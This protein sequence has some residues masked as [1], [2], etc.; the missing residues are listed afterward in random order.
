MPRYPAAM[1][2]ADWQPAQHID[3]TSG[4]MRWYL[5]QRQPDGSWRDYSGPYKQR[6]SAVQM[7]YRLE[8]KWL[9]DLRRAPSH[10]HSYPS[11]E[12]AGQRQCTVCRVREDSVQTTSGEEH[13]HG[14][15]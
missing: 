8:R 10:V 2:P 14:A 15:L 7:F 11:D 5:Q 4:K 1:L 3:D 13:E 9:Q 6:G 12:S